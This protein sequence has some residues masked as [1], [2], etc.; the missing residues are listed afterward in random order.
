MCGHYVAHI[1]KTITEDAVIFNPKIKDAE[2]ASDG[3]KSPV[4]APPSPTHMSGE[5]EWIIF[6]DNKV[7][8]SEKPPIP[9]AYLYIYKRIAS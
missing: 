5:T 8:I 1:R 6:N 2:P 7:N 9:F 3:S 4:A